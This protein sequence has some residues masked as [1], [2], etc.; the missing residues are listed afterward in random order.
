MTISRK[1]INGYEEFTK[2]K[3][4]AKGR[5]L[6]LFTG[7]KLPSGESWC[8]DCVEAEPIIEKTI[9]EQNSAVDLEFVTCYVGQRDPWKDKS[10]KFRTDE[11]LKI[12]SIPTLVE[13]GVKG[14]RLTGE[15][16]TNANLVKD[17][18]SED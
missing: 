6:V 18:F 16:L 5:T 3:E 8:P 12:S 2:A 14:K 15:Q 4:A 7:S 10:N 9:L 11:S 13:L 17:F 1:T